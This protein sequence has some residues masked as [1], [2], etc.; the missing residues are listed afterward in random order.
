ERRIGVRDRLSQAL[1]DLVAGR[2]LV[3]RQRRAH[4]RAKREVRRRR[5]V[6]LAA[7]LQE[8]E[9]GR[10]LDELGDESGLADP[11]SAADLDHPAAAG[12][13]VVTHRAERGELRVSA[14]ERRLGHAL[15][16]R[17]DDRADDRRL[18]EL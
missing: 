11:R 7:A 16:A 2:A 17:A 6:L 5:L 9:A 4:R 14:D 10:L 15:F 12:L 8:A 18:D 13:D 3:E 1:L